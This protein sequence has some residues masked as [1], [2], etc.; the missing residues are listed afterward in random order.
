VNAGELVLDMTDAEKFMVDKLI[1]DHGLFLDLKQL[2][3]IWKRKPTAML[4]TLRRRSPWAERMR[5]ARLR[6]G[7]KLYW[8]SHDVAI[9]CCASNEP[10]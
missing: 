1:A 2:A 6:I 10:E 4:M 7:R 3:S 9:I 8:R 5:D